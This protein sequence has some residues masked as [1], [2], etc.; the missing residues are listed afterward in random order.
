VRAVKPR[1]ELVTVDATPDSLRRADVL[2][3]AELDAACPPIVLQAMACGLPVVHAASGGVPELVGT[4]AGVG[5]P[6]DADPAGLA[7]A[8]LAVDER[9]AEYAEA[10]RRR[11]VERFDIRPWLDRHRQ[12][13]EELVR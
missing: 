2:L 11:A 6:P 7:A 5:I 9:R 3:Y 10:A 13:F 4:E 12:I 1:A 8:V